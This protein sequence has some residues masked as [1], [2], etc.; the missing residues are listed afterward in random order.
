MDLLSMPVLFFALGSVGIIL[1]PA[2]FSDLV[3]TLWSVC[4]LVFRLLAY[5]R[6]S[7]H[8]IR[9]QRCRA[10]FGSSLLTYPAVCLFMIS[11]HVA[12]PFLALPPGATILRSVHA[13]HITL[14][15][16]AALALPPVGILL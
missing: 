2:P 1:W 10:V 5:F 4:S 9:Y 16:R 11:H 3:L 13:L 7:R 6:M 15:G 8:W 12:E 14:G